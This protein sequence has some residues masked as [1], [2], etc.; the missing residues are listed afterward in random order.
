MK[1]EELNKIEDIDELMGVIEFCNRMINIYSKVQNQTAG[2]KGAAS[3]Y[4]TMKKIANKR[5]NSIMGL[6]QTKRQ[7]GNQIKQYEHK[8]YNLTNFMNKNKL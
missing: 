5:I 4:K 2:L 1:Y 7:A 3:R 6:Q 8:H